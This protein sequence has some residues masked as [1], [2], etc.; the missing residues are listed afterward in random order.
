MTG[1]VWPSLAFIPATTSSLFKGPLWKFWEQWL[2][3]SILLIWNKYEHILILW[4][5]F[6]HMLL[7]RSSDLTS[8]RQLSN[9]ISHSAMPRIRHYSTLQV[10]SFFLLYMKQMT[11]CPV[12]IFSH[13]EDFPS[14]LSLSGNPQSTTGVSVWQHFQ[15]A[16]I[17]WANPSGNQA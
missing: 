10:R 1:A 8:S 6:T 17:Y 13:W 16:P 4:N 11:T 15:L 14:P 2:L 9:K 5:M 12:L 3:R 7:L